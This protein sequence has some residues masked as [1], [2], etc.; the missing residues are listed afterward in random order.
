[1]RAWPSTGPIFVLA[2]LVLLTPYLCFGGV[3]SISSVSQNE[4]TT[5]PP[6]GT[7]F[8]FTVTLSAGSGSIGWTTR[9]GTAAAG[10]DYVPGGGTLAFTG[11]GSQTVTVPVKRNAAI[12]PDRIFYVVLKDPSAGNTISASCGTGTILD[13]DGIG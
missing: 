3:F 11:P 7:P 1:M 2:A 5:T 10:P 8:V 13:D 6:P 12:Q 9:D 4:G